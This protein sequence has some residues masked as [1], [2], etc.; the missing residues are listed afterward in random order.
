MDKHP[1]YVDSLT[2]VWHHELSPQDTYYFEADALD[3]ADEDPFD[4]YKDQSTS[5]YI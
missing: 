2:N 4:E 5:F 1:I 3:W